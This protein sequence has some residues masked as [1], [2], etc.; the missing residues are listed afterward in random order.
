MSSLCHEK[1]HGTGS[2]K[3]LKAAPVQQSWMEVSRSREKH[4]VRN[5]KPKWA[6]VG[7]DMEVE[8]EAELNSD[9]TTEIVFMG[10]K[11]GTGHLWTCKCCGRN[12]TRHKRKLTVH[13]AGKKI[14]ND[15][16]GRAAMHPCGYDQ[17][18]RSICAQHGATGSFQ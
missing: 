1:V 9:P 2:D 11:K 10:E 6:T 5:T 7:A 17:A 13:I 14:L 12:S 8:L 16:H 15:R 3:A 4:P 18:R